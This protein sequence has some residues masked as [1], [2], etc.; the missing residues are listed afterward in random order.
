MMIANVI[1]YSMNSDSGIVFAAG[2]TL[3]SVMPARNQRSSVPIQGPS[4]T[5]QS[6]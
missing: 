2:L 6:E 3:S 4:P 1:W 5:K